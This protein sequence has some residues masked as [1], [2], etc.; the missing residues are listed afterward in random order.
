MV[1]L[2]RRIRQTTAGNELAQERTKEQRKRR[3][4]K[5]TKRKG[6]WRITALW[7]R[8]FGEVELE[9]N[10]AAEGEEEVEWCGRCLVIRESPSTSISHQA[11]SLCCAGVVAAEATPTT[12]T[13][14]GGPGRAG[15]AEATGRAG[16]D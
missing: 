9:N 7:K 5:Q 12:P 2:E 3:Q 16:H 8:D 13:S 1:G 4:T 6:Q 10:N 14:K 11:S 15:R